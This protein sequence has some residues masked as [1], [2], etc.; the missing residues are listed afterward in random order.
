MRVDSDRWSRINQ[1]FFAAME[2]APE[3]RDFLLSQLCADDPSLLQEVAS[4]ISA[5]DHAR[6]TFLEQ[7]VRDDYPQW[8]DHVTR[9]LLEGQELG[10]YRVLRKIG[11]GGMAEVHLAERCDNEYRKQV[12]VKIIRKGLDNKR[13]LRHFCTE[14]QILADLDHPYITRLLDGGTTKD[15]LPYL[16]VEYV[17]GDRIDRYCDAHRLSIVERLQ[18]FLKICAAVHLS[19]IHISEPTRH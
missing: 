8:L 10:P 16:I 2:V 1:I 7:P 15:G 18:L 11:H 13:N 3:K 6:G 17:D 4:L 19:L 5:D 12:A 14:R 9:R